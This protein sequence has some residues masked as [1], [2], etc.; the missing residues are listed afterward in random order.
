[1]HSYKLRARD[2][3][4]SVIEE[5]DFECLSIAGALDK[6]KA[7]VKAVMPSGIIW[8]AQIIPRELCACLRE[9]DWLRVRVDICPQVSKPHAVGDPVE[10]TRADQRRALLN[11]TLE[12]SPA[13]RGVLRLMGPPA[14][15][16]LP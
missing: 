4:N 12:E 3:H 11:K 2:D 9:R 14:R 13:P 16:R 7:M 8:G 10:V 15:L 1:M 5:I 6:A